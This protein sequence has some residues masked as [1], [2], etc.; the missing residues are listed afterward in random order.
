MGA[1]DS[2]SSEL[3]RCASKLADVD[4]ARNWQYLTNTCL[5]PDCL[6]T[7]E[8]R[9]VQGQ[10]G[11]NNS[12][13]AALPHTIFN[14]HDQKVAL[15]PRPNSPFQAK[16]PAPRAR[17]SKWRFDRHVSVVMRDMSNDPDEHFCLMRARVFWIYCKG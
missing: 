3:F 10:S 8:S 4:I 2:R 14:H 5:I 7:T 13:A 15:R 11:L 16:T 6:Q 9:G 17:D 12:D 1:H